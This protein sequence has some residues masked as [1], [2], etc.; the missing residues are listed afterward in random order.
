MI[1]AWSKIQKLYSILSTWMLLCM[2]IGV[3]LV[4]CGAA[5]VAPKPPVAGANEP[6]LPVG[7]E[8]IAGS[9][10]SASPLAAGWSSDGEYIALTMAA[11]YEDRHNLLYVYR[12]SDEKLI[13]QQTV[14]SLSSQ[15][16]I[17]DFERQFFSWQPNSHNLA[18]FNIAGGIDI[19]D[20]DS[21]TKKY[22]LHRSAAFLY[23]AWNQAGTRLVTVSDIGN[24]A[25]V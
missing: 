8:S 25:I 2:G 6:P 3:V 13:F 14:P 5:P 24:E 21:I 11:P 18:V 9:G 17:G 1:N 22:S 7:I 23:T 10:Y 12:L 4:G 19:W 15:P 16:R 20:I